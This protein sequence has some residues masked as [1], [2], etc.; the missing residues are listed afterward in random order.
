MTHPYQRQDSSLTLRAALANYFSSFEHRID[1]DTLG[2]AAESFWRHDA[3]HVVF[4]TD[5]S[6]LGESLTDTWSLVGTTMTLRQGYEYSQNPELRELVAKIS[7]WS[8]CMASL[9]GLPSIARAIWRGLR[10]KK[11]WVWNDWRQHLD[12]PLNEIRAEFGIRVV[13]PPSSTRGI[14]SLPMPMP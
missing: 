7:V 9:R 3:A 14:G 8:V 1:P 10:M 4:G 6:L 13:E 11:R 12:R 5:T 2:D